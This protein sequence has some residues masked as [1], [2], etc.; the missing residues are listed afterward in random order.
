MTVESYLAF[1]ASLACYP[2]DSF[3]PHLWQVIRRMPPQ[4]RAETNPEAKSRMPGFDPE[5]PA[6]CLKPILLAPPRTLGGCVMSV[7]GEEYDLLVHL[8][9]ELLALN[10][11]DIQGVIA[12]QFADVLRR[13]EEH[14]LCPQLRGQVLSNSPE[15]LAELWGFHVPPGSYAVADFVLLGGARRNPFPIV[16]TLSWL[17]RE[18]VDDLREVM[19]KLPSDALQMLCKAPPIFVAPPRGF[20]GCVGSVPSGVRWNRWVYLSPTL[21]VIERSEAQHVIAHEFAH[22]VLGHP[23]FTMSYDREYHRR[24]EEEANRLAAEWGFPS[25]PEGLDY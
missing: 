13:Q 2:P 24:A 16:S 17:G 6:W 23:I 8:S 4:V 3:R 18:Y 14:L 10:P 11:A 21:L 22:V 5:E 12:V 20:S 25:L 7:G 9:P 15:E 1:L 19:S